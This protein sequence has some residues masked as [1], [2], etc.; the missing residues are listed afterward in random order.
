MKTRTR[1]GLHAQIRDEI[2][3]SVPLLAKVPFSTKKKRI[4]ARATSD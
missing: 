4:S 3:V 1:A 2:V